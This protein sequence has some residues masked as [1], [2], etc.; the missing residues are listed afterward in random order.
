MCVPLFAQP[1]AAEQ[2]QGLAEQQ[3][4]LAENSAAQGL[5][6][7]STAAVTFAGFQSLGA[8]RYRVFVR[9]TAEPVLEIEQS[10]K[11]VIYR[12]EDTRVLLKNNKNPLDAS[13]FASP[14]LKARLKEEDGDVLLVMT[15]KK[16]VKPNHKFLRRSDGSV[17]L[18]VDF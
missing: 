17:T 15:F 3:Q 6:D 7:E 12:L 10:G 1:V 18:Q 16:E 4:G 5:D 11:L 14:L 13:Y 9:L 8:G 2:Q